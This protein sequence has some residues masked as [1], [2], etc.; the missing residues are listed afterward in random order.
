MNAVLFDTSV[1]VPYCVAAH[2][3]RARAL[4]VVAESTQSS[5]ECWIALHSLAE[6]FAVL[7][8]MPLNP[9]LAPNQALLLIEMEILPHFSMVSPSIDTYQEAMVDMARVGRSGGAIYDALIFQAART[10]GASRLYTFNEKHFRPLL[11]E[12]ESLEIVCPAL[13]NSR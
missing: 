9:R 4:A 10:I 6:T 1:L 2:P 7:S 13:P 3:H 8:A 11:R 12:G 5:L